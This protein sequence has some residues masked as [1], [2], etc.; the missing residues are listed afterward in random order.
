MKFYFVIGIVL[1][2]VLIIYSIKELNGLKKMIKTT[3]IV[4]GY[5]RYKGRKKSRLNRVQFNINGQELEKD[6]NYYGFRKG[7]KINVYYDK[8][9]TNIVKCTEEYIFTL[10]IG[11]VF[12]ILSIYTIIML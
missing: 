9:N 6:L 1:G 3:A 8:Y 2:L 12:L 5:H 11:I 4:I 10:L 7:K